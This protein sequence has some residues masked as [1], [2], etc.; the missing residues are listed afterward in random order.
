MNNNIHD[1]WTDTY[2]HVDK[3][4]NLGIVLHFI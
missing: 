2:T 3:G 1:L 4:I